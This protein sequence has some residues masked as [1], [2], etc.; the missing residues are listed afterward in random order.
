MNRFNNSNKKIKYLGGTKG[1]LDLDTKH[2]IHRKLNRGQIY[3]ILYEVEYNS[4]PGEWH[5]VFIEVLGYYPPGCFS[6][7]P[8]IGEYYKLK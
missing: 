4:I 6:K 2:L 3:T 1:S 8:G 5:Y 7:P